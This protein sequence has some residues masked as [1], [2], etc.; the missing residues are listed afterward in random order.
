M[1][2]F[3]FAGL[4]FPYSENINYRASS[5]MSQ[6]IFNCFL[7]AH[8]N[9]AG[10]LLICYY[11]HL[12]LTQLFNFVVFKVKNKKKTFFFFALKRK[13]SNLSFSK[14]SLNHI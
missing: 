9:L 14:T 7:K 3:G 4:F 13:A 1:V 6:P 11:A 10:S 12:L 8:F 5:E 2:W